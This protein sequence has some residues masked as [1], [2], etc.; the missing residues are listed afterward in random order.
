MG[1]LGKGSNAFTIECLKGIK[2][3]MPLHYIMLCMP[4]ILIYKLIKIA[5]I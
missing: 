4:A 1:A 3:Y 2:L 5:V